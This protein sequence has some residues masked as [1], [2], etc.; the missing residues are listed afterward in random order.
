MDVNPGAAAASVEH[1][2]R[3]YYFCSK[4]CAQKFQADPDRFTAPRGTATTRM[5]TLTVIPPP[6]DA[7]P[8]RG[9][10]PAQVEPGRVSYTCPMHPEIVRDRPGSCPIC[11]MALEPM[12]VAAGD[13]ADPEL[14]DMS[15]RFWILRGLTMPL[16]LSRWEMMPGCFCDIAC[17]RLGVDSARPAT[18]VVL[19]GGSAVLSSAAGVGRQPQPNMFT[20]IALGHRDGL[21]LQPDRG[22]LCRAFSRTRSA[23]TARLPVYFEP[24][25]V[26]ITL[27]LL[28][29]VLELRARRQT[30]SAIR[31][32]LGWR[33]RPAAGSATME[34]RDV[35][36]DQVV[37]GDRLRVR[38]GEKIP[39]DGVVV[40]GSSAVDEVD[41][42]RRADPGRERSRRPADRRHGQRHRRA[43]DAG[44]AG[45]RATRC[46]PRSCAW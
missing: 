24:A 40:E 20:L 10:R 21:C 23:I 19:W 45:R 39:V 25:A 11:G 5:P 37:P 7:S 15:R 28:G 3:T 12:S 16:V 18:P 41:D 4:H 46:W 44:R 32:L 42:H 34:R 26:I 2:G 29:Q 6:G 17:G 36:L 43:G 13:D 38:P 35:P 22:A 27:V 8:P 14:V 9:P 30:G 33:P 31:A 1:D